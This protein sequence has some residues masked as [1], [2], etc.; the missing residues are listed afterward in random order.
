MMASNLRAAYT[1]AGGTGI[2]YV[3]FFSY[4][5]HRNADFDMKSGGAPCDDVA[6]VLKSDGRGL[7]VCDA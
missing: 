3:C 4:A 6:T 2:H 7:L 5:L 1:S